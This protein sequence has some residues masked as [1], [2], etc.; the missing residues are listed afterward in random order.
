MLFMFQLL[1]N[2]EYR[3]VSWVLKFD[4]SGAAKASTEG[5]VLWEPDTQLAVVYALWF[6]NLHNTVN[7][8]EIHTLLWGMR[9][10]EGLQ[11]SGKILLLGFSHLVI[12]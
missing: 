7:C 10:L 1:M 8:A 9:Q 11:V 5:V 2:I 4:G 3:A 12:D 6:G